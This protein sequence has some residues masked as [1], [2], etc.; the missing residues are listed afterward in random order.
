MSRER[1]ERKRK[2]TMH[3][4]QVDCKAKEEKLRSRTRR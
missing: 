3:L 2:K 4:T 1:R